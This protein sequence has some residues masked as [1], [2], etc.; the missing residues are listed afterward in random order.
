MD[1]HFFYGLF[2]ARH[3]LEILG[4]V[5]YRLWPLCMADD[6]PGCFTAESRSF[7]IHDGKWSSYRD[8]STYSLYWTS[9][10]FFF[11]EVLPKG[12]S[13]LVT[14]YIAVHLKS[15]LFSIPHFVN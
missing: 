1:L 7:G 11:K 10:F 12:K 3:P 2:K 9:H 8:F 5:R 14:W 6:E 13:T 4:S 15:S